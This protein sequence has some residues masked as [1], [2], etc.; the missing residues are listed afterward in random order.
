MNVISSGDFAASLPMGLSSVGESR[1][2]GAGA[3][4]KVVQRFVNDANTQQLNADASVERLATGQ[5]DSVHE[6]MLALTKADL[7]LRVFMEVRNKVI[8]A[9]QE[10]M[11][12]QL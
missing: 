3:F 5:T 2:T 6:T 8:E 12:M 1:S 11:R 10:V 9:Y 7:S 4:G